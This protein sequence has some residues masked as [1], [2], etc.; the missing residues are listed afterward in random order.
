MEND[1]N[2][3][4]LTTFTD[5]MMGLSYECEPLFRK[6]ETHFSGQIAFRSV[7]SGLVRDVYQLVDPADLREGK[8]TAIRRY[9]RRLAKIYE[10]EESIS[11]MPI[12]MVGF[13]LFDT[14]H[15]SSIPLNLA[16][17]A[18]QLTA[19]DLKDRFLYNLRYA[20]IVQCRPTTHLEEILKVA[21]WTGLELQPF[22]QC[23][24]DGRAEQALEED[25]RLGQRLGIHSLPCYLLQWG[26]RALLMQSFAYED[27]VHAINT[28][29][30]GAIKSG[31]VSPSVDAL[32]KLLRTHPLI[33]PIEVREALDLRDTEE[34]RTLL[35]PLLCTGEAYVR[36]V[37]HGWFITLG[38]QS[39]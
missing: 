17:K 4:V 5:P 7:M 2:K 23:Y 10:D 35:E 32:C 12:N 14:V 37:P 1:A 31:S 24:Q 27:F 39:F 20:T 34:V 13:C 16:Y 36:E 9:N 3:V 11:G 19:S 26:D 25:F 29:T 21:E 22:L 18:A 15:T 8:E 30:E 28:L 6:L 38:R 33:S